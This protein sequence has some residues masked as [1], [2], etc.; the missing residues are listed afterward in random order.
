MS[1]ILQD[2][3]GCFSYTP[4]VWASYLYSNSPRYVVAFAVNLGATVL[5]ILIA[6][7]TRLYLGKQNAKIERGE[8]VGKSGPTDA[9][10]VAGFKY[11][12]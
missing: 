10:I 9:Q 3:L 5:A 12:L 6:T 8:Q 1:F 2:A 11:I 4:A 7:L